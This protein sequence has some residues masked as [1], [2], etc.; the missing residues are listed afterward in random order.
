MTMDKT[1]PFSKS[2]SADYVRVSDYNFLN[3]VCLMLFGVFISF[4]E[5]LP[6]DIWLLQ[7][8]AQNKM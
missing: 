5:L 2:A 8:R 3:K 1:T 7:D 4:G 6:S